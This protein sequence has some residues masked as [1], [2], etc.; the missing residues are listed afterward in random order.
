MFERFFPDSTVD[1][2]YDI[3]YEKLYKEG[4]RGIL[5]DIDNTLVEH[6]KEATE[7]AKELFRKL[8]CIGFQCCLISNNKKNR[9]RIP[10][11]KRS[12]SIWCLM[13]TNRRKKAIIMPWN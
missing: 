5:F 6:G 4:Y 10:L 2:T 12:V 8:K 1:S 13:H 11:T 3:N 9:V 7:Q